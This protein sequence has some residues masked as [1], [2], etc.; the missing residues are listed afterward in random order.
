M[1]MAVRILIN[2]HYLRSASSLMARDKP[3]RPKDALL[4]AQ[5]TL[6]SQK[7]R[8]SSSTP[9][10]WDDPSW[11]SSLHFLD[12]LSAIDDLD[13]ADAVAQTQNGALSH[14]ERLS[15]AKLAVSLARKFGAVCYVSPLDLARG[16]APEITMSFV[17][18]IMVL[19]LEREDKLKMS[20]PNSAALKD[21]DTDVGH[22]KRA[23]V[24]H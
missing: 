14:S 11:T 3:L 18:V 1:L 12:L 23:S 24:L 10:S 22:V 21:E 9:S 16:T 2:F 20:L 4:W 7:G 17:V 19:V 5:S 13:V 6:K 8:F 15:N